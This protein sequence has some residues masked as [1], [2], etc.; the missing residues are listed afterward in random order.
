MYIFHHSALYK[1]YSMHLLSK[2]KKKSVSYFWGYK[3]QL[4]NLRKK[5]RKKLTTKP[6]QFSSLSLQFLGVSNPYRHI[7]DLMGGSIILPWPSVEQTKLSRQINP[8][9]NSIL[10]F[11]P[12]EN[13]LEY[14]CFSQI[15]EFRAQRTK[16]NA[17]LIYFFRTQG[18]L[19]KII[20]LGPKNMLTENCP[21][22]IQFQ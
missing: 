13:S 6:P 3:L 21:A 19:Q 10:N 16:L 4:K 17:L 12:L 14:L 15:F 7:E 22:T 11:F 9:N 8:T 1:I 5:N 18:L 20:F 2:I